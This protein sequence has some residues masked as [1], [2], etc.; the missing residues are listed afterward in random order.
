M[1]KS[2]NRIIVKYVSVFSKILSQY[3]KNATQLNLK[4]LKSRSIQ[5]T[6]LVSVQLDAD[7]KTKEI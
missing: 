1:K 2:S 7:L 6:N 3:C 5:T 4:A